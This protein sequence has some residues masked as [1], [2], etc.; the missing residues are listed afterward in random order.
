MKNNLFSR[1][2]KSYPLLILVALTIA[3]LFYTQWCVETYRND[4]EQDEEVLYQ[5]LTEDDIPSNIKQHL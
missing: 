3:Q 4:A 1:I 2:S 5:R